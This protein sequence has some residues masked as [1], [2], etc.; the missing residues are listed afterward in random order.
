MGSTKVWPILVI[1]ALPFSIILT[2]GILFIRSLSLLLK[3]GWDF[4]ETTCTIP[5]SLV[6][7]VSPVSNT[8]IDLLLSVIDARKLFQLMKRTQK[9]QLPYQEPESP[10]SSSKKLKSK[11]SI[12]QTK[13]GHVFVVGNGGGGQL[14]QLH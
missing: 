12:H 6:T 10:T 5:R 2:L 13:I 9:S 7:L 8:A 1:L 14:G 4:Q 3:V 11:L